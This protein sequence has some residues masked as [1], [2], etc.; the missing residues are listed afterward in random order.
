[1]GRRLR[2]SSILDRSCARRRAG[3]R[4]DEGRPD[5]RPRLRRVEQRAI[6]R[7]GCPLP[8]TFLMSGTCDLSIGRRH[9]GSLY[10]GPATHR[11]THASTSAPMTDFLTTMTCAG[12]L[13]FPLDP[14][15]IGFWEALKRHINGNA[16]LGYRETI[17]IPG[18]ARCELEIASRVDEWIGHFTLASAP[19]P[20]ARLFETVNFGAFSAMMAG[21]L[22]AANQVPNEFQ[23]RPII[24]IILQLE[25][26]IRILQPN[27]CR[28]TKSPSRP[29]MRV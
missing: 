19:S 2:R 11:R 6:R 5:H 3:R 8:L 24:Q 13:L 10:E 7:A 21:P 16:D 22:P 28:N 15:I 4:R 20:I 9:F 26:E 17:S 12:L 1:M 29:E 27:V 18:I 14:H 23:F 25:H